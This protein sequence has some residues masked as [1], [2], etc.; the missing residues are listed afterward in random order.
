MG[1][2]AGKAVLSLYSTDGM[3]LGPSIILFSD[4][5]PVCNCL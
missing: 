3:R 2:Y 1:D 4:V 5:L